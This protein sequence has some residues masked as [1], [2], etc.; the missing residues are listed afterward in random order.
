MRDE[1]FGEV[2]YR[3]NIFLKNSKVPTTTKPLDQHLKRIGSLV[4]QNDQKITTFLREETRWNQQGTFVVFL[5]KS[6]L[7]KRLENTVVKD[8]TFYIKKTKNR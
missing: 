4:F 1:D 3:Y 8:R 2:E 6:K 7:Q 5:V